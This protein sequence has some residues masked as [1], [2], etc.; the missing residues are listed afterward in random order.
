[1]VKLCTVCQREFSEPMTFCPFD[2]H[3]LGETEPKA[4]P[5]AK[6][7]SLLGQVL[8]SKYA[9]EAKIGEGSMGNVYRAKHLHMDTKVAIKILHDHLVSDQT[10]VERFRREARAALIISHPNAI[11]VMDFGISENKTVYLVMEFLEGVSLRK[12]L[13]PNRPMPLAR[14]LNLSQQ[15][16]AALDAAHSHNIIHRDLKPENIMILNPN[17]ENEIVKVLDF[18][19]AKL[20]SPENESKQDLTIPGMVIGTPQYMSPE[21]AEGQ[22]LDITS[23]I[24]S[25]GIILYEMLAGVLPFKAANPMALMLKHIHA[26]PRPLRESL[27]DIP[28]ALDVLISQVLA[29]RPSQR[30]QQA[31][32]LAATLQAIITETLSTSVVITNNATTTV[33]TPS[34]AAAFERAIAEKTEK[35]EKATAEMRK[36]KSAKMSK[37]EVVKPTKPLM[38]PSVSKDIATAEVIAP[39]ATSQPRFYKRFWH[40]LLAWTS[41]KILALALK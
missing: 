22:N 35:A 4:E 10:T 9:I 14:V 2:G 29:K 23:D 19:I 38:L 32:Q 20:K 36:V 13:T 26:M 33:A 5:T 12:I 31:L 7:D 24:Y 41:S 17:T 11:H 3:R 1:M 30:P 37:P 25:L 39:K 15:I 18:S 34:M 21:Q 27:P 40:K 16:C 28:P 8:D 6:I